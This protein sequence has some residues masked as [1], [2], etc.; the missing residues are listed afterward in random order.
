MSAGDRFEV[1]S[2]IGDTL[3][4]RI[5]RGIDK[6]TNK[7]VAIKETWKALVALNQCRQGT[8]IQENYLNEIRLLTHLC[9]NA[10][11][12]S[13]IIRVV[14]QWEEPLCY[15][16]AMEY[17]DCGLFNYMKKIHEQGHMKTYCEAM[18]RLPPRTMNYRESLKN[19]FLHYVQ[20]IFIKLVHCIDYLHSHHIVHR[21]LSLENIMLNNVHEANH[22][23]I[24]NPSIKLIDFGL[25]KYF[26][27]NPTNFTLTERCG[28]CAYMAPEVYAENACYD[29]RKADIWSLGTILFVMLIGTHLVDRP[30]A[31]DQRFYYLM[32]KGIKPLLK[33]WRRLRLIN[34]D[35]LDLMNKIFQYEA[36]RIDM[37]QLLKHPFLDANRYSIL[38]HSQQHPQQQH[39]HERMAVDAEMH[40]IETTPTPS[41]ISTQSLCADDMESYCMYDNDDEEVYEFDENQEEDEKSMPANANNK[42]CPMVRGFDFER[43]GDEEHQQA[44][45]REQN[46]SSKSVVVNH[47]VIPARVESK[48]SISEPDD[49]I[50]PGI[51][52]DGL[53]EFGIKFNHPTHRD[54]NTPNQNADENEVQHSNDVQQKYEF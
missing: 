40:D 43:D 32:R 29:A 17:C 24:E 10:D 48:T 51:G 42:S 41:T 49:F 28:K 52:K 47:P 54:A 7:H 2:I 53:F 18:K 14:G 4:G 12:P 8:K 33:N 13:E 26:G 35:V 15:M 44:M 6:L 38:S 3:Q 46:V 9:T 5:Y 20:K 22:N 39:D 1:Q 30:C 45:H 19:P 36:H 27:A 21:D 31:N 11:C 16:Y 50:N 34:D 25:A 23:H 37:Q